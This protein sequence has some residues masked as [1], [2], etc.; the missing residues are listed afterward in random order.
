MSYD[1]YTPEQKRQI[2]RLAKDEVLNFVLENMKVNAFAEFCT[3]D[4]TDTHALQ[5][6]SM[7]VRAI[8]DIRATLSHIGKQAETGESNANRSNP[9]L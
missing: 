3:I 9:I 2:L 7:R 8:D 4:S 6:V 1:P 5:S